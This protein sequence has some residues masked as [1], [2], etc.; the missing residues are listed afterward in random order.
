MINSNNLV[1]IFIVF[2]FV[3]SIEV[4]REG[5]EGLCLRWRIL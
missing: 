1:M 4:Y 3:F 2:G 5:D